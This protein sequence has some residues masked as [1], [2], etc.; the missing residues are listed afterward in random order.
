MKATNLPSTSAVLPCN[1]SREKREKTKQIKN[2]ESMD[3]FIPES[4]KPKQGKV[5]AIKSEK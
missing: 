4:T 1:N 5:I 2:A 3:I